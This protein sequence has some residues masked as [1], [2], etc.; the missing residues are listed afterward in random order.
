MYLSD[1]VISRGT[2]HPFKTLPGTMAPMTTR[3]FPSVCQL[4]YDLEREPEIFPEVADTDT[5]PNPVVLGA[6]DDPIAEAAL[7]D[8]E[9]DDTR[10]VEV[11]TLLAD[12]SA[13]GD[14][15]PAS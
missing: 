15:G 3:R 8:H 5:K 11:E 4:F 10:P 14:S 12:D 7:P 1:R 6:S 13:T 2:R 9:L